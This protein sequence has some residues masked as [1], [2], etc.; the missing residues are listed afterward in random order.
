[1]LTRTGQLQHLKQVYRGWGMLPAA[2]Q[3]L[4]QELW[5]RYGWDWL[6]Y[7]VA[8]R[9]VHH[10]EDESFNQVE[11]W[12][13]TPTG[14]KGGY[15]AEVRVDCDRRFFLKGSCN[16]PESVEMYPYVLTQLSSIL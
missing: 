7:K 14:A 15:Q 9:V 10:N 11:V 16:S 6:S 1:I 4:E 8:G 3:V 12:F 5:L 2:V 13:E